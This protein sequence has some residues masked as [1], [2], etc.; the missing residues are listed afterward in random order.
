MKILHGASGTATVTGAES[1]L[2]NLD[3][4][5]RVASSSSL[6]SLSKCVFQVF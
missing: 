2:S 3:P 6:S 5:R 1:H 4:L